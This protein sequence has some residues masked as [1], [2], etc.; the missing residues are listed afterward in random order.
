MGEIWV[1]RQVLYAVGLVALFT[2]VL[3]ATNADLT[4]AALLLARRGHHRRVPWASRLRR[5]P[6][7]PRFFALNWFFTPPT[8]SLAI[9]RSDDIVA[10]V[11]FV[12]TA[13][14]FG[15]TVQRLADL[16]ATASR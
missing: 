5:S 16:A 3:E 2:V 14:L 9:E 15:V 4:V 12:V 7:S 8:G 11:V 1:G 6:P 13:I 10:L